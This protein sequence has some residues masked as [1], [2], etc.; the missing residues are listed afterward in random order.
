[1]LVNAKSEHTAAAKKAYQAYMNAKCDYA[2]CDIFCEPPV[3][4]SCAA[5]SAASGSA[6]VCSAGVGVQN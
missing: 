6:F 2:Q 5:Q 1:V 4:A 3:L